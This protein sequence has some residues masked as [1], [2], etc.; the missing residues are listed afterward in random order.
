MEAILIHIDLPTHDFSGKPVS[1][2]P[3]RALTAR[4]ADEPTC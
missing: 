3:D 2:F 1:T 4:L